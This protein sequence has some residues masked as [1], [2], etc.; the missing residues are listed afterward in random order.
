MSEIFRFL[1]MRP[2]QPADPVTVTPS[3]KYLTRLDEARNHAEGRVALRE[4]SEAVVSDYAVTSID[5]LPMARA[6]LELDRVL[7]GL[8]ADPPAGGMAAAVS[9]AVKDLLG[10][11]PKKVMADP[12]TTALSDELQDLLIAAKVLSR[13]GAVE[14]V[15]IETALRTLDLVRRLADG[16]M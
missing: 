15:R 14:A 5:D 1:M 16:S 10:D 2:P 8:A 9:K 6:L 4:A 11:T 13:D 7:R 3:S 12:A